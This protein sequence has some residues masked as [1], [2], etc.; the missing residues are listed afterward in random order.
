MTTSIPRTEP[1]IAAHLAHLAD[2]LVLPHRITQAFSYGAVEAL[3]AVARRDP[4]IDP[5]DAR[6]LVRHALVAIVEAEIVAGRVAR[7]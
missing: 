6:L 3:L 5:A 4:D 7:Q 1:E 2:E